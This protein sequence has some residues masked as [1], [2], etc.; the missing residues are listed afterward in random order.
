MSRR[1][2]LRHP[3]PGRVQHLEQRPVAEAEPVGVGRLAIVGWR[4][5][6]RLEQRTVS[7]TVRVSGSSRGW[8][9]RSRCAATSVPIS[10]SPY[11]NR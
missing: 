8:R 3:E 2:R 6:G 7:S 11:A 10:P 1:E 4:V 5:A 9:G